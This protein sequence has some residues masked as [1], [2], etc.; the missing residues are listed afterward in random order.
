MIKFFESLTAQKD[1]KE[2]VVKEDF[3]SYQLIYI[4]KKDKLVNVL[5][6]DSYFEHL[7]SRADEALK[8][9]DFYE[10]K[11]ID[12]PE[13]ETDVYDILERLDDFLYGIFVE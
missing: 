1:G 4:L 10:K 9:L 6:N 13:A 5:K 7:V 3:I 8:I 11:N 2:K 12:A